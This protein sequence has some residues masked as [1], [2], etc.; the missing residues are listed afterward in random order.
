M[1][2]KRSTLGF[3][4]I[5]L[6]IALLVVAILAAIAYP[7]YVN[8]VRKGHRHDGMSALLDAAQKLEVYRARTGSYTTT[9]ADANI[10]TTSLE[11]YYDHLTIQPGDCADITN[12]Y[13][14]EI[15]PTNLKNQN[16][17]DVTAY[18][19]TSSGLKQRNEGSWITGWK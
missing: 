3:T 6:M 9:P 16:Q 18:R 10:A 4:L 15:V 12:C 5:E 8:S 7:S 2:S 13:V 17:D 11:G 1:M 19:L 14:M